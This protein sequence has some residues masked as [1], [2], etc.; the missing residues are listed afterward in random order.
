MIHRLKYG[1]AIDYSDKDEIIISGSG[2]TSIKVWNCKN[3]SI[4]IN[5]NQAHNNHIR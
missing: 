3:Y 1:I 2:D 5:K 4:I